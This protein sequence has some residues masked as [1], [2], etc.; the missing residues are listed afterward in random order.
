MP[1]RFRF[2]LYFPEKWHITVEQWL[3]LAAGFCEF[4]KLMVK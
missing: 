2:A 1:I 3:R 4:Q